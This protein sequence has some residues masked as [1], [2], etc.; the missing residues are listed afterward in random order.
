MS[1]SKDRTLHIWSL[2]EQLQQDLDIDFIETSYVTVDSPQNQTTITPAKPGV[3]AETSFSIGPN[4]EITDGSD[5]QDISTGGSPQ[6]NIATTS[7]P[8]I[9]TSLSTQPQTPSPHVLNFPGNTSSS[10]TSFFAA[11][12]SQTLEQ[13]FALLNLDIPNMEMEIVSSSSVHTIRL[14]VF[15]SLIQVSAAVL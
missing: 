3:E 7:T 4:I 1:L 14:S 2:E 6:S 12:P 5:T 15:F 11:S 9:K 8:H 10:S 13:E